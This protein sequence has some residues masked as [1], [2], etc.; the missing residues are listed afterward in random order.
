MRCLIVIFSITFLVFPVCPQTDVQIIDEPILTIPPGFEPGAL[1]LA[2]SSDGRLLAGFGDGSVRMIRT[3]RHSEIVLVDAEAAIT[4]ITISPD[5]RAVLTVNANGALKLWDFETKEFMEQ[6]DGHE[7]I[8]QVAAW[9]PDGSYILSGSADGKASLW[10]AESGERLDRF[11]VSTQKIASVDFS[12][13][14]E[15]FLIASS[16]GVLAI[17]DSDAPADP[18]YFIQTN[19]SITDADLSPAG[20]RVVTYDKNLIL[21]DVVTGERSDVNIWKYNVQGVSCEFSQDGKKLYL[22]TEKMFIDYEIET[23]KVRMYKSES[24]DFPNTIADLAITDQFPDTNQEKVFAIA[25]CVRNWDDAVEIRGFESRKLLA[26]LRS[27]NFYNQQHICDI[28]SDGSQ[29]LSAIGRSGYKNSDVGTIALWNLENSEL[30]QVFD[31]HGEWGNAQFLPGEKQLISG[32]DLGLRLWETSITEPVFSYP[33]FSKAVWLASISPF[34]DRVAIVNLSGPRNIVDVLD[35][36]TGDQLFSLEESDEPL[37]SVAFSPNGESIVAGGRD[38][39]IYIYDAVDGNKIRS[40]EWPDTR[41]EFHD[42]VFT[43]DGETLVIA[44]HFTSVSA[45]DFATC[46]MKFSFDFPSD[47]FDSLCISPDGRWVVVGSYGISPVYIGDMKTG[48]LAAKLIGNQHCVQ[49]IDFFPDGKRL[50]TV[51]AD[52]SAMIWD[53]SDLLF[54]SSI[55]GWELH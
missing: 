15:R 49:S 27:P 23:N 16:D 53:L 26:Y 8:I 1:C 55:D 5:N 13:D 37:I 24:S 42:I 7:S 52:G 47:P 9:S 34:G 29:L 51:A 48:K 38:E 20:Q 21:W 43:P 6:L 45:W 31:E 30:L 19:E 28:S 39:R 22:A 40:I 36:Q 4:V 41:L 12:L 3:S 44:N 17:Y 35:V 11:S 33:Q 2:F 54:A 32:S 18:I 50:I 46:E 10:D 25:Y 14:S